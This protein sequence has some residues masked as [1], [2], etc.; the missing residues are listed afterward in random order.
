MTEEDL[1][2]ELRS[3]PHYQLI[4]RRAQ[5]YL[6]DL[7]P[8]LTSPSTSISEI[9]AKERAGA[10]HKSLTGFFADLDNE[11]ENTFNVPQEYNE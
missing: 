3:L 11:I 6:G 7:I 8:R 1:L 9:L 4:K 5:A 2:Q 10:E